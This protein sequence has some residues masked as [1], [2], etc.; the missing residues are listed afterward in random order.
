MQPVAIGT[1]RRDRGFDLTLRILML[2]LTA[3]LIGCIGLLAWRWSHPPV[4]HPAR[5]CPSPRSRP[6]PPPS[7]LTATVIEANQVLLAPGSVFRCDNGGTVTFSDSPCP[8][9]KR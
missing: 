3:I 2:A 5:S 4:A 8:A 6:R 9:A 1:P 7:A